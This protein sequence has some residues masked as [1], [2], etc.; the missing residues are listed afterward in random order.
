MR[1]FE[2]WFTVLGGASR[3]NRRPAQVSEDVVFS[4]SL[5][6]GTMGG[7][8]EGGPFGAAL[9][10]NSQQA[11]EENGSR[12][13]SFKQKLFW[14]HQSRIGATTKRETGMEQVKLTAGPSPE[15]KSN[16]F[17]YVFWSWMNDL[18]KLGYGKPLQASDLYDMNRKESTAH[19]AE[20]WEKAWG[21]GAGETAGGPSVLR[22]L[23][24]CFGR[25]LWLAALLKPVWLAACILQS[26]SQHH[27]FTRCQI[28]G[29]KVRSTVCVA[30]YRKALS[31]RS[32]AL[33]QATTGQMLNLLTN[34]TQKLLDATV[35]F[36]FVWHAVVELGVICA[37]T[38][39]EA[40]VAAL[41]GVFVIFV[42]QPIALVMAQAVGRIRRTAVKVTD[43]RVRLVS[44]VLTGIRVVKYNGWTSSFLA[45]LASLRKAEMG[46]IIR[47]AYLRSANST[48]KDTVTPLASLTTFGIYVAI[49]G[50]HLQP[51]TAF[52]VLALFSIMV[53]IF[54]IA[55][56]AKSMPWATWRTCD[57][58][59]APTLLNRFSRLQLF[60]HLPD[61]NGSCDPEDACKLKESSPDA[62]LALADASFSW[63]LPGNPARLSLT[64]EPPNQQQQQEQQRVGRERKAKL[65]QG[66]VSQEEEEGV[67][68]GAAVGYHLSSSKQAGAGG[69]HLK[70]GFALKHIE[71]ALRA[72]EMVAVTGPVGSGKSSL[73]M[74]VLSEMEGPGFG[75]W[76]SNAVQS[77]GG[78]FFLEQSVAYVP[79]QPW[80]LNDTV[81]RNILFGSAW[82]APRYSAVVAAC[83]LQHDIDQLPA[84]HH[85]EIGERGVNL[86]GGQKA[87]I[88]LA[89]ACYS[90]AAIVLLDDPLAAVDVPTGKHLMEHV[91]AGVLRDRA[92]LLVTHNRRSLDY[93]SRIVVMDDGGLRLVESEGDL[94][95]LAVLEAEVDDL[96][97]EQREQRAEAQQLQE[98]EE[99]PEDDEEDAAAEEGVRGNYDGSGGLN[100]VGAPSCSRN[101]AS[102][103]GSSQAAGA[104]EPCRCRRCRKGSSAS[105][106]SSFSSRRSSCSSHSRV[107]SLVGSIGEGIE[108]GVSEGADVEAGSGRHP[109]TSKNVS[110]SA[111]VGAGASMGPGAGAGAGGVAEEE[112]ARSASA[113]GAAEK[114]VRK[115]LVQVVTHGNTRE[116]E[117]KGR[118][119][120][121][122]DRVEGQVTLKTYLAY[123]KA[124]GGYL[125]FA[126]LMIFFVLSQAVRTMVDYWLGV[127]VD[128]KYNLQPGVY[129]ASYAALTA[130]SGV[131]SLMR[132]FLF[133]HMAVGSA[134][135]MHDA[136]AKRVLRSP[137]LFF[138][139]NP[140][141][142]VLNRFSKDQ[143]LV[144]ELLPSTA[145]V[146]LELLMGCVG[147]I[148]IIAVLVPW[149]LVVLPP[150]VL[151]FVVLQKRY[152]HVSRELKRLDGLSR[153]PI[154]AHFAQSLQG[155]ASVRAY[156][157]TPR[158]LEE[159]VELIDANHRAY[160]L[161]VHCGRWLGVRLDFCAAAI[162]T[163]TA[164][165]VLLLR[166]HLPAGLAGRPPSPPARVLRPPPLAL[167]LP[168]H[169]AASE[170]D[171]ELNRRPSLQLTGL[172]QYGVRQAAETENYF[173][174]V[175]RI[176]A[177]TQLPTEADSQSPPGLISPEWPQR[178]EIVFDNVCMAYREDLPLVLNNLSFQVGILGRT[179]AGKSS[180]AAAIFR[181]VENTKN[182]GRILI[183]DVDIAAIGLDDLRQRLS[184]IPQDP[185]LFRGSIRQNLDPFNLSSDLEIAEAVRRVHLQDKLRGLEESAVGSH[186]AAVSENG[187]NFSVGQRQLLCLARALLRR[188]RII[189]M[190]EATAAVDGE[191]DALIQATVREVFRDCTVLTIAHRIDTVIDCHRVLLL[192]KGGRIAEFD[193][194]ANLL[195]RGTE[196][197]SVFAQMVA[198]TGPEVAQKLRMAA[199]A[200]AEQRLQ[201]HHSG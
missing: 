147:S 150:C 189:V 35:Y 155:L 177:Y 53:R 14:W 51:G 156:G 82:D 78:A 160:V 68:A 26:V 15:L 165:C 57:K 103:S 115:R 66:R 87:R 175:E 44:E 1:G 131:L 93:C 69:E 46:R 199:E 49:H 135:R 128:H 193:S 141:G 200:A 148:A 9:P 94:A 111:H 33:S 8:G 162:V 89:R 197:N 149:F 114:G 129:V 126:L 76:A 104:H 120:V 130:A 125:I 138:D 139:Q 106:S 168:L 101:G 181:M 4:Y 67:K 105:S 21:E 31:M 37:L 92:T 140:V 186:H 154:Y 80:I 64:A 48:V 72:G 40:G 108:E 163:A 95:K 170:R 122:E 142:R 11:L 143:S 18:V 164:L 30:V 24:R 88:S 151:V 188:S 172:F 43:Q 159:Y 16:I 100:P 38:L 71:L 116:E 61:G 179:G 65:P 55:P 152:V 63:E 34:D 201:G 198:Q 5:L 75:S 183:D 22:A 98:E 127:W 144:D 145:Q 109:G 153:S 166:N 29:M 187:D 169:L 171:K 45:R 185:V 161:F 90:T 10:Q 54:F 86:S 96:Q 59:S 56:Q 137:Q 58:R 132:A 196:G 84:G 192:A 182:S 91:L 77:L 12:G 184:I 134:R 99:Q 113:A 25:E 102:E 81:Q 62:M 7:G 121:S 124:G 2:G 146:T 70:K 85:T 97:E 13:K 60:L 42:F 123:I 157:A 195:H 27:C 117:D 3:A 119:T 173:T 110:G 79:Q 112:P 47:A 74:A 50:G 28:V 23:H 133:T 136:M 52:T 167:P 20:R 194:P 39:V 41:G 6:G 17:A 174:S 118:L 158:F 73:L 107:R 19:C 32:A 180:L 190:D 176:Y 191:T 36:H 178:G 83:A